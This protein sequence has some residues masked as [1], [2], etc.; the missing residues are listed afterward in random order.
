MFGI[1]KAERRED[2]KMKI[3]KMKNKKHK[4]SE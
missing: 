3:C 4:I 1:L 2:D